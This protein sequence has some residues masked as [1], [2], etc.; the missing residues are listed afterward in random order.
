MYDFVRIYGRKYTGGMTWSGDLKC[1]EVKTGFCR[2]SYIQTILL[3][4]QY[5]GNLEKLMS[6]Y[7][8]E[9]RELGCVA[10]DSGWEGVE[11]DYAMKSVIIVIA[12]T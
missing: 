1:R 11:G 6:L 2:K 8:T 10:M 7:V 12:S 5:A 9:W 3:R 4:L